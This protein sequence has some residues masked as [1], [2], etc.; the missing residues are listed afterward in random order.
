MTEKQEIRLT[1][2]TME[3]TTEKKFLG[4]KK[5]TLK[6]VGIGVGVV[7]GAGVLYKVV[8]EMTGTNIIGDVVEELVD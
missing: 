4:M 8:S 3:V 1:E 7:V 5:S 2:E 6:K